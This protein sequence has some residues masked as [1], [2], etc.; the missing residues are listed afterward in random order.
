M[1][2]MVGS[3]AIAVLKWSADSA[4]FP[5]LKAAVPE[6]IWSR[7]FSL[8]QPAA[9]STRPAARI[10]AAALRRC[11]MGIPVITYLPQLSGSSDQPY[12][13][14][15]SVPCRWR[16]RPPETPGLDR[17]SQTQLFRRGF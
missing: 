2:G 12:R 7:A 14:R 3:K 6:L 9:N 17:P 5:A 10:D 8:S 16:G 4:K 11:R 13:Y 1:F 15:P